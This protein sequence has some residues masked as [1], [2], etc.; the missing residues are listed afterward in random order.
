MN[1]YD[2]IVSKF[3]QLENDEISLAE[4]SRKHGFIVQE[5]SQ[6]EENIPG[7]RYEVFK[8]SKQVDQYTMII[9]IET[10]DSYRSC[11]AD[12][13]EPYFNT[14][15]LWENGNLIKNNSYTYFK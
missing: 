4:I 7:D 5:K 6:E 3:N 2:E 14:I 12:D 11:A 9:A 13:Q 15:E 10:R 8:A 1:E